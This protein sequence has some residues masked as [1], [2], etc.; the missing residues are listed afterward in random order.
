MDGLA[1]LLSDLDNLLVQRK[2]PL[3]RQSTQPGKKSR[4]GKAEGEKYLKDR[5]WTYAEKVEETFADFYSFLFKL[6]LRPYV[7]FLRP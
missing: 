5:Y 4:S 2:P 7:H 6:V 3:V 1:E